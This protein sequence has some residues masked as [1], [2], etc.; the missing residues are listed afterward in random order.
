MIICHNVLELLL[1]VRILDCSEK[2]LIYISSHQIWH[3]LTDALRSKSSILWWFTWST[4]TYALCSKYTWPTMTDDPSLAYVD[5]SC[6]FGLPWQMLDVRSTNRYSAY[7]D[8]CSF[9][10]T[11][12]LCDVC[13]EAIYNQNGLIDYSLT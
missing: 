4:L 13:H 10:I 8:R 7:C 5:R 11:Y 12:Q 9:I 2:M 3:T 6:V 1:M